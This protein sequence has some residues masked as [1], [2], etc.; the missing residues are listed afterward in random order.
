MRSSRLEGFVVPRFVGRSP[1]GMRRRSTFVALSLV[2]RVGLGECLGWSSR[3]ESVRGT[4]VRETHPGPPNYQSVESGDAPETYWF[5]QLEAPICIAGVDED[6]V[7]EE[8]S[9]VDKVQLLLGPEQ[10]DEF[11]SFLDR[12][13]VATGRLVASQTG[14]HHASVLLEVS[15]MRRRER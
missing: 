6:G 15:G 10:Y 9:G 13:V 4:V 12:E 2:A 11:R 3:S 8:E 14:H 5:L 1:N 7:E